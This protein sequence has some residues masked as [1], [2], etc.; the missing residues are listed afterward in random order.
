VTTLLSWLRQGDRT[1]EA[2]SDFIIKK[3]GPPVVTVA[4]VAEA[5]A[6][7]TKNPKV[8]VCPPQ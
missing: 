2:I 5:E 6:F 8:G 1:A 4:S 3:S 7:L